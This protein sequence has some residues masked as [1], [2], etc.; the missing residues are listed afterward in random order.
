MTGLIAIVVIS[1]AIIFV[2][3]WWLKKLLG[4]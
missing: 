3:D 4:G 2:T 1:M